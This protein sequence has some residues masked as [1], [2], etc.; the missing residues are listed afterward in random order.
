MLLCCAIEDEEYSVPCPK[1][2]YDFLR[3]EK[4]EWA[5][6]DRP[7]RH[8]WVWLILNHSISFG[9]F[10][11]SPNYR[12]ISAIPTLE[13]LESQIDSDLIITIFSH[14]RYYLFLVA[15]GNFLDCD[16]NGAK[17]QII[18]SFFISKLNGFVV[19]HL[20][21]TPKRQRISSP[22]FCLWGNCPIMYNFVSHGY[23][24]KFCI[25]VLLFLVIEYESRL[26]AKVY[27]N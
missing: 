5:L 3:R 18:F 19:N 24:R 2:L 1:I 27:Q 26:I 6:S 22:P 9:I 11:T 13:N 25:R 20:K 8:V 4:C 23:K 16:R 10:Y 14:W 15:K 12:G 17:D 7:N 21:G